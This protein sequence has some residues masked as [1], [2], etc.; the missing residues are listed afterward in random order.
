[1]RFV[2]A[3]V[4]LLAPVALWGAHDAAVNPADILNERGEA[5]AWAVRYGTAALLFVIGV[6]VAIGVAVYGWCYVTHAVWDPVAGQCRLT[7][8]GLFIPVHVTVPPAAESRY[9]RRDGSSRAHGITV[10]A[11]YYG[12]RIPGRRLPFIVDLQGEFYHR[13]LFDRVF[14]GASDSRF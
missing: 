12:I 10:N 4:L 8:A 2:Q 5:V 14:L 3:L 6:G 13:D 7:L 11:P 9:L 1:V